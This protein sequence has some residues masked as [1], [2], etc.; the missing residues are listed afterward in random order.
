MQSKA[1]LLLSVSVRE[2]Q[3]QNEKRNKT[4]EHERIF[5]KALCV[6]P[7]CVRTL[8]TTTRDNITDRTNEIT[9][10]QINYHQRNVRSKQKAGRI[11]KLKKNTMC[12]SDFL[13]FETT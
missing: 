5:T 3:N 9:Y 2:H 11:T 1:Q 8:T 7:G 4:G 12:S 6:R 10:H 13:Y